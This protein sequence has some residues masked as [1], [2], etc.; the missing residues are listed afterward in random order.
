MD[1]AFYRKE[2]RNLGPDRKKKKKQHQRILI[3]PLEKN[4]Q[5][6]DEEYRIQ[7]ELRGHHRLLMRKDLE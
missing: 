3:S 1:E 2:M 6:L 5:Y 7:S 4:H